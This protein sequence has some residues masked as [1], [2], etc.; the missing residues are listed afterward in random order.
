MGLAMFINNDVDSFY[1]AVLNF[2][3]TAGKCTETVARSEFKNEFV[4]LA[5]AINI[6]ENKRNEISTSLTVSLFKEMVKTIQ[7][8]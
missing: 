3:L 7:I 8:Y 5:K 2:A 1:Q 6:Y 4:E